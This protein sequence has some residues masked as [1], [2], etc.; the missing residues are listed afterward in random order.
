V[1]RDEK[2]AIKKRIQRVHALEGFPFT[3]LELAS[4]IDEEQVAEVFVRINSKGEELKQADFIL[5]LMSVFWDEGR[6]ELEDFCRRSRIP[7][8]SAASPFNHFIEPS[9]DQL[10]R[11]SVAVAF[12]RA[13]LQYVYS[14]LRG[15]DLETGEVSSE[16]REAQ[17]EALKA[18]QAEVL[19]LQYWHDY[20]KAIQLAGY[21]GG[22]MITSRTNLVYVYALYLLGRR[23]HHVPEHEL[24]RAIAR[25]FFM[26]QMTGRYTGSSEAALEFDL[27]QLEPVA[28]ADEFLALVDRVCADNLTNDFWGITLPNDLAKASYYSPSLSAYNAALV[29][30][31]AKA[32]FSDHSVSDLLDPSIHSN[33]SAVE[34]H[35]LFPRAYLKSLGMDSKLDT[36]QIAN[37]ALTDWSDNQAISDRPPAEYVPEMHARWSPDM[38]Q[39]M[40]HWHALPDGWQHMDYRSFLEKRRELMA[41]VVREAYESLRDEQKDNLAVERTVLDLVKIGEGTQVEFK[42]TLRV[43]LHTGQKDPRMEHAVIKTIAG[44]LNS[45]A[46]GRLVIG[47]ADDG[48]AVGLEP[49]GFPNEDKMALHLTNLLLS[50]MDEKFGMYVH[51]HFEDYNGSRALVVDC[52]P[53]RSP[54]YVKDGNTE[55]FYVRQGPSTPELPPSQIPDYIKQRFE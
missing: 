10:L 47:V 7:T 18:A 24:R 8:T 48:S 50:R 16:R 14:I 35:H 26:A 29:L 53:A 55:R 5:T 23:R 45:R 33:R 28:S 25:W 21:R 19:N 6:A 51:I 52:S 12:G 37:Y 22:R 41:K 20:L 4:Q 38:L 11:V 46:G 34:R 39:K 36:D 2:K 32:L 9:P 1:S 27:R 49:D 40:Y 3:A 30:L 15:K 13:R 42:S 54:A 31:D 17:F 43:N 44:F